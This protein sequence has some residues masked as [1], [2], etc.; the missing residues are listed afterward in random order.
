MRFQMHNAL[1]QFPLL[2]VSFRRELLRA[3][4]G[5]LRLQTWQRNRFELLPASNS[6]FLAAKQLPLVSANPISRLP[7]RELMVAACEIGQNGWRAEESGSE[8]IGP[9]EAC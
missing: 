1:C 2:L 7:I 3:H 4:F 9:F 8:I 6:H 5:V